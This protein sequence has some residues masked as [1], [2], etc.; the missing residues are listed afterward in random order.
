MGSKS[1]MAS[2]ALVSVISAL[3]CDFHESEEI[4]VLR[5]VEKADPIADVKAAISKGDHRLLAV[6]GL[7]ISLPGLDDGDLSRYEATY[8][9]KQ[10]E[11]TTD[12]LVNQ[13]HGQL[14]QRASD[15]AK[16][17]NLFMIH[18]CK[19]QGLP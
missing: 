14:V 19:L 4:K 13:K 15:Y 17:Y 8:G 18:E 6:R 16:A 5:W 2:F 10:I 9:V 3:G 12:A 7:T 1:L 11:G